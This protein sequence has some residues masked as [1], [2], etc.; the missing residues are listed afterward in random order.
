[1]SW[2]SQACLQAV[3]VYVMIVIVLN[4]TEITSNMPHKWHVELEQLPYWLTSNKSAA[5]CCTIGLLAPMVSFV[6]ESA[7]MDNTDAWLSMSAPTTTCCYRT[8]TTYL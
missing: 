5:L 4:H 7:G 1:M 2:T 3:F 6:N 8:T